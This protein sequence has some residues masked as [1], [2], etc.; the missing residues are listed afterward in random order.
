MPW[1]TGGQE[2]T[3]NRAKTLEGRFAENQGASARRTV[4]IPKKRPPAVLSGEPDDAG[5]LQ[6]RFSR[7]LQAGWEEE[8]EAF[9][10]WAADRVVP[11]QDFE[12]GGSDSRK[13]FRN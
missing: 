6:L 2:V 12:E 1:S 8:I 9:V 10:W 4:V 5:E 7:Y 13:C 11:G 3:I